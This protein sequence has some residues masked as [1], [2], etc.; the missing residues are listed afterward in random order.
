MRRCIAVHLLVI[1]LHMHVLTMLSCVFVVHVEDCSSLM[2]LS[3]LLLTQQSGGNV[4]LV[5]CC[6]L[7]S[8]LHAVV[9]G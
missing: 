9:S 1:F 6:S 4:V 8:Q 3:C 7:M 5:W 2:C